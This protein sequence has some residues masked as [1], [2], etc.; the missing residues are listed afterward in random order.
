MRLLFPTVIHEIKLS[1]FDQYLCVKIS[2]QLKKEDSK[3]G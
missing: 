1:N 3:G 2:K